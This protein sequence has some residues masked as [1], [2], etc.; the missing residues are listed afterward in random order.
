M[1]KAVIL[2]SGGLD[3]SNIAEAVRMT[4][5]SLLDVSSG[6][7]TVPGV[8]DVDKIAAFLKAASTL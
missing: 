8:K 7:E 2:L 4:N 5:A 6:V 3:S 1:K